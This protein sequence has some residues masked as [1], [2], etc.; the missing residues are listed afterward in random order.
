MADTAQQV[1][2]PM[3]DHE[4]VLG[5]IER[6]EIR[7]GADAAREIAA[8]HQEAYGNDVWGPARDAAVPIADEKTS[9]QPESKGRRYIKHAEV[10]DA[11]KA[12][13]GVWLPVGE[14]RTWGG[15]WNA[16]ERIRT[17]YRAPAYEPA[18]AF[19]ARTALT[20]MGARV[21]ARY[22]GQSTTTAE[23]EAWADAIAALTT[24]G[25]E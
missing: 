25:A 20:E 21:E 13:P 24:G 4:R 3:R 6:G 22:V 8:R 11:L 23:D 5:Q 18:G 12:Q 9:V 14:Y 7:V 19:E 10:A 1:S 17:A 2:A 16:A 15:A